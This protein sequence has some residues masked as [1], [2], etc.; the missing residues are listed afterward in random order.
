[1]RREGAMITL[2]P[3]TQFKIH[4]L[5]ILKPLLLPFGGSADRSFVELG[6]RRMHCKFG[7]LFDESFSY[8]EIESVQRDKWPW[9]G[10]LGWRSDLRG[11]I[12]I[13]GSYGNIVRV[14]LKGDRRAKIF[15]NMPCKSLFISLEEPEAFIEALNNKIRPKG[16]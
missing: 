15:F 10:G 16:F 9:Y 4:R 13:V 3:M 7:F 5:P 2:L 8:D 1:M 6:E 14:D 12:A 11:K